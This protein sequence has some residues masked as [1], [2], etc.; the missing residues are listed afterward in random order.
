MNEKRESC[1][2]SLQLVLTAVK[3]NP[4]LSEVVSVLANH[5]P[6]GHGDDGEED[7]DAANDQ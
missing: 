3:R 2:D 6:D 7:K 4:L 5:R 1:V